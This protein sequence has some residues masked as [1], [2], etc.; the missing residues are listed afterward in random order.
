MSLG[1]YDGLELIKNYAIQCA[2]YDIFTGKLEAKTFEE[3]IIFIQQIRM[4]PES[5]Y[6]VDIPASRRHDTA[7]N[8]IRVYIH[9]L[10]SLAYLCN[11]YIIVKDIKCHRVVRIGDNFTIGCGRVITYNIETM[12]LILTSQQ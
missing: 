7:G 6:S 10:E 9:D 4:L 5:S 3:T 11:D 8:F 12:K 1:E 2:V